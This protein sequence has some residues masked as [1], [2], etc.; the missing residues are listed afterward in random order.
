ME[1]QNILTSQTVGEIDLKEVPK[2]GPSDT[3][4]DAAV[5]MRDMKHGSTLVCSDGRLVGIFTERDWLRMV[6]GGADLQAL[7]SDVMTEQP[8]T[9]TTDDSLFDAIR[10]MD[11]GGYRRV[12]VVDS[13]G[14]PVGIVDVKTVIHFLVQYFPAAVYNQA[15]IKQLTATSPEGA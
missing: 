10:L 2:L 12:P 4:T 7:L 3:V 9:V 1:L 5:A 8:Q 14:S 13:S 6:E 15:S 11:E